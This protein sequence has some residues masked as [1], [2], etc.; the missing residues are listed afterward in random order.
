MANICYRKTTCK[1]CCHHR[2]DDEYGE[3]ACFLGAKG[4]ILEWSDLAP[5]YQTVL[6]LSYHSITPIEERNFKLEG[7]NIKII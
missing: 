1:N 5:E 3:K 2:Y 4:E 7:N 6:R